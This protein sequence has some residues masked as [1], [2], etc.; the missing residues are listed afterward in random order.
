VR[1][2]S[3]G[4]KCPAHLHL[5]PRVVLLA[6]QLGGESALNGRQVLKVLLECPWRPKVVFTSNQQDNPFFSA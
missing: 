2:F 4:E 1:V 5:Q 3:S 6:Y